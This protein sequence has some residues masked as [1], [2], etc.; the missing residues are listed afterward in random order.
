MTDNFINQSQLEGAAAVACS[1]LLDLI[2]I[3]NSKKT[4]RKNKA[5]KRLPKAHYAL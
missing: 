4:E 1:D 3:Y 5:Q 2:V